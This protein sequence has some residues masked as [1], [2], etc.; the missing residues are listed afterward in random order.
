MARYLYFFFFHGIGELFSFGTTSLDHGDV[1]NGIY[2]SHCDRQG[3]KYFSWYHGQ[4]LKI[5]E[6]HAKKLDTFVCNFGN[7]K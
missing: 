6:K 4:C 2:S 1:P 5:S 3:E 7:E